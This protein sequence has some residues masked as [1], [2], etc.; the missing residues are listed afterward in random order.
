[1]ILTVTLNP[2]LDKSFFV[3]RNVP[4]ETLRPE[5]VVDLAGGKGVNV[6]RALA[7]LG[8]T[9][10]ALVP[11]G[12]HPGAEMA[13]LARQ[14]GLHPIVVPISG[15]TRIALT[16]REESTGSCWHYLEPGP[17]WDEADSE[18]LRQAYQAAV[19]RCELVVLSG[20]LP[21][22]TAASML[23]WMV[24]TARAHG[25]R[26]VVDSHGAG[27][28]AGLAARPWLVKPNYEELAAF[29]DR[30]LD[31]PAAAWQAVRELASAGIAVVL[32]SA[33][34]GP[35]L[36]SWDGEEW[37]ALP[38]HVELVNALGSGDSLVAGVVAAV[39]QGLP[40]PEALRWGVACGA[41]NAAVW[42]PGGI[43]REAVARLAP[44]VTVRRV[45]AASR[46]LPPP[47]LPTGT[48]PAFDPH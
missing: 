33:G 43:R 45:A 32:L 27:L 47:L 7:G 37:E 46:F 17:E 21:C 13:D 38:P 2:C 44:L 39:R 48:S 3:P 9:A 24:E 18:R 26:A 34:P 19:A 40:P 1:M 12:G 42:D 41:A 6:A 23:T 4:V 22:A 10:E 11:L 14:E 8:E 15:R 20:S 29:L 36:A 31:E 16:I 28:R 25:R 5:R 35:L 30:P